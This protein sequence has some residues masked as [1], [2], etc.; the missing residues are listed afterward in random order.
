MSNAATFTSTTHDRSTV[1]A[2]E[3]AVADIETNAAKALLTRI[4]QSGSAEG[5]LSVQFEAQRA[6]QHYSD[7]LSRDPAAI[8]HWELALLQDV[9][10]MWRAE[11]TERARWQCQDDGEGAW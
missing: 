2:A 10:R 7:E 1:R 6:P 9:A 8:H 4:L 3:R 11:L 5:C